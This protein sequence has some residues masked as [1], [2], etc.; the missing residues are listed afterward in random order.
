MKSLVLA[1][2]SVLATQVFADYCHQNVATSW[3]KVWNYGHLHVWRPSRP[4]FCSLG[5]VMY[6]WT[7]AVPNRADFVP[8]GFGK[9]PTSYR[10]IT[11][12]N[13]WGG[14]NFWEPI[15]PSGYAGV[16]TVGVQLPETRTGNPPPLNAVC[17]VPKA[18]A[19]YPGV[20]GSH[21]WSDGGSGGRDNAHWYRHDSSLMFVSTDGHHKRS[22]YEF[23]S[24]PYQKDWRKDV[25]YNCVSCEAGKY[26]TTGSDVCET[27][28]NGQYSNRKVGFACSECQPGTYSGKGEGSCKSCPAGQYADNKMATSCKPCSTGWYSTGNAS[29]CK[30]C[31][32]GHRSEKFSNSEKCE[33]CLPG[34][35]QD[36]A[37]HT[38]KLCER[39]KYQQNG[40]QSSC[41]SCA[42]T[43][44][45]YS[46]GKAS[47]SDC[48]AP[49]LDTMASSHRIFLLP[50]KGTYDWP[51]VF[52]S[53][54]LLTEI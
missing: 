52:V 36:S 47:Q 38:C 43:E 8:I 9:H 31:P 19:K 45:T 27:C 13:Q 51:C 21:I 10:W 15:C 16:G 30:I 54:Q 28:P 29:I 48:I 49:G 20:Y 39:G 14:I 44:T 24:G 41:T 42:A 22:G 37:S 46:L 5:D 53:V 50:Q 11:A 4:G 18:Y 12:E 3:T 32:S 1:A 23:Y 17:C 34:Q 26:T 25:H 35:Y 6:R 33:A 2:L 40:G 7:Y